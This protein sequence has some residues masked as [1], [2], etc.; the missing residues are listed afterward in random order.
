MVER[1]CIDN[2]EKTSVLDNQFW[3]LI[4][5]QMDVQAYAK[6]YDSPEVLCNAHVYSVSSRADGTLYMP[7]ITN[8][9]P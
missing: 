7:F 6:H 5:V 4:E 1:Y 3:G 2:G 8:R 9:M